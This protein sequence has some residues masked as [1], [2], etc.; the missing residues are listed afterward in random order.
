VISAVTIRPVSANRSQIPSIPDNDHPYRCWAE[1]LAARRFTMSWPTY[2][3][4]VFRDIPPGSHTISAT[5]ED[6]DRDQVGVGT[7][8]V[9]MPGPEHRH[10][11]GSNHFV[12]R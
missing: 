1:F 6:E 3:T 7:M 12:I 8:R 9:S 5:C 11:V 10:F 4:Y 2:D